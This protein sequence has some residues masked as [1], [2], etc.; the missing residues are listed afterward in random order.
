MLFNSY[1]FIFI[2]FPAVL[3]VFQILSLW[4]PH[5]FVIGWLVGSSLFFYGWWNPN[6]LLLILT[7]VIFNFTLG[8]FLAKKRIKVYLIWGMIV[9]IGSLIYFK[10]YGFLISN[11]NFL[12][13]LNITPP[14]IVL[15][16]A[17]SFFTFQQVAYLV[18]AY[19]GITRQYGFVYYC[20]FVTF[21]PQLI[22][23]PIVQYNKM[24]PQFID[25]KV[26]RLKVRNLSVG[27]SVFMV[28][29]FKKTVFAD[30]LAFYANPVFTAAD[31]GI[32]LS[33]FDSWVGAVA[34]TLQLYFDFS[35]YSDMAIGLSQAFGITLPI[36]FYSPYKASSII[37]FWRR[38]HI[39]LSDFLKDR[40]Y[41]P[42]G[43][44]RRGLVMQHVNILITMLIGGIWHGSGWTFLLW[45]GVH[46]L[47][48][49]INHLWRYIFVARFGNIVAGSRLYYRGSQWI[50]FTL[51]IV[52]WVLFRAQTITGIKS[53]YAG[54]LGLNG[55]SLPVGAESCLS[56]IKGINPGLGISFSGMFRFICTPHE[57]MVLIFIALIVVWFCPNSIEL[58]KTHPLALDQDQFLSSQEFCIQRIAWQ[59]TVIYSLVLSFVAAVAI[60][61][62]QQES[63]FLYFQF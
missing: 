19:Q 37:E 27:I 28:G 21:F 33:F 1:I 42:L 44:N 5:R 46:G 10:Y 23:G 3:I 47:F 34:Y 2:F 50:T 48:L 45:G 24:L 51:V 7:S 11:V 15:P 55:I 49:S 13:G 41:I 36:N 6:Y 62:I 18:D 54:M 31:K 29:L 12:S 4:A 59:P 40:I 43:G 22:A 39:T 60:M 26:V 63:D 16:L 38:W 14:D 20:L 58:F 61:F 30:H 53:M 35:G 17:I 56:F 52:A 8:G 9:N 57:A 25:Y 32:S